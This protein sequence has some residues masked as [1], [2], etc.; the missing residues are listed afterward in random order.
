MIEETKEISYLTIEF[1][2]IYMFEYAGKSEIKF[3]TEKC[4]K[5]IHNVQKS[6]NDYFTFD[7]RLIGSGD[8]KL[9]TRNGKNGPFD[10]DYNLIIQRD[11]KN[12]YGEPR[13]IKE[14]FR[15]AFDKELKHR[16]INF[17]YSC[18]STSVLTIKYL[19]NDNLVFSFDVAILVEHNDGSYSRLTD[20]KENG[21]Q[22]YIWNQVP[23]SR[24]Y[25]EKF[26]KIKR[27]GNWMEFKDRYLKNKNRHLSIQDGV[28]SFSIFLETINEF[29]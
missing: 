23:R 13:K 8:K 9:V 27:D 17:K 2:G 11:K 28:K 24:N 1:G 10:L 7:I 14:L 20:I 6:L 4:E 3:L 12:L 21:T 22:T 18:D 25:R 19:T 29:K 16:Y 26:L 5:I 15:M